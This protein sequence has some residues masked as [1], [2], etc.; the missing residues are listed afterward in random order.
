MFTW[1]WT[2]IILNQTGLVSVHMEPFGTDL[3]VY[4]EPFE[5]VQYGSKTGPAIS[6]SIL[7]LF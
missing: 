4:M 1:D 5:L 2:G 6:R 7:D 3:D